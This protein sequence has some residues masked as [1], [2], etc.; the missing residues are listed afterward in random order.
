MKHRQLEELISMFP[1]V[2]PENVNKEVVLP[3]AVGVV[4]TALITKFF[5]FI[6]PQSSVIVNIVI[7]VGTIVAFA[8]A[9]EDYYNKLDQISEKVSRGIAI[10][11]STFSGFLI[12]YLV[13]GDLGRFMLPLYFGILHDSV[14]ELLYQGIQYI[15]KEEENAIEEIERER[16][17]DYR[18]Y[19][20]HYGNR[21]GDFYER[22]SAGGRGF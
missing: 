14:V 3:I 11:I 2:K 20:R 17:M 10:C 7:S 5:N 9:S 16:E 19:V 15:V 4:S 8:M 12:S 21:Y 18:V 13:K 22:N 1:R 6:H